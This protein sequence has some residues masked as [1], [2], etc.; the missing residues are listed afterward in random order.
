[1]SP[2]ETL[3]EAAREYRVDLRL[4]LNDLRMTEH[5]RSRRRKLTHRGSHRQP[6]H[7]HELH[8]AGP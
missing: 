4:L 8:E 3:A 2:F 5:H 1:M 7:N 6:S